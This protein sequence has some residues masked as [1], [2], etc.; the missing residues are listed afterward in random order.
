MN[1]IRYRLSFSLRPKY[2]DGEKF[3]TLV[4]HVL[5]MTFKEGEKIGK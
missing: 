1:T 2:L 3:N 4:Q 5:S